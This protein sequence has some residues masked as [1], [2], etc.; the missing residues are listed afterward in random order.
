MNSLRPYNN[1]CHHYMTCR[2]TAA[3]KK[4]VENEA[5][6]LKSASAFCLLISFSC[7]S[8]L[9]TSPL[10]SSPF[11]LSLFGCRGKKRKEKEAVEEK[12]KEKKRSEERNESKNVTSDDAIN[13][14]SLANTLAHSTLPNPRSPPSLTVAVD[15]RVRLRPVRAHPPPRGRHRWP[16]APPKT[17][18]PPPT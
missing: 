6:A 17:T 18:S 10:L 13:K 9:S 5:L 12:K 2:R 1:N 8:C 3:G 7:S 11:S 14:S 4:E 16:A 15:I